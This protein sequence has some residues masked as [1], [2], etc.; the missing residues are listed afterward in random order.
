[1][2]I[3]LTFNNIRNSDAVNDHVHQAFGELIKITDDKFPFHVTLNKVNHK[4]YRVGI[5]CSYRNKPISSKAVHEN[6]YKALS[7]SID[8]MKTQVIRKAEKVRG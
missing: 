4:S 3:H 2:S 5:N 1:M 8:S 6:L 7:K